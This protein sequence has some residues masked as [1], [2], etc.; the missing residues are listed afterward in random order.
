MLDEPQPIGTSAARDLKLIDAAQ[1]E[2]EEALRRAAQT[3]AVRN[4]PGSG[5]VAAL[6]LPDALPGY[7]IL[8][9]IHRGGQGV[10]YQ[11][12]QKSTQRKV[13]IKVLHEGPF[14]GPRSRVRFER[15][16]Q[17]LGALNHPNIVT[18]HDSGRAAGD[19]LYYVMDYVRGRSLREFVRERKLALEPAL[20]LFATVCEAVQHAHTRGIIHRDLKPGNILVDAEGRAIVVDFGFGKLLTGTGNPSGSPAVSMTQ[21]VMGT[22]AY[23]SPEQTHG[24]ADEIDTRTDVYS[25]GVILYELLT[26][27]HPYTTTG[28][29]PDVVHEIREAEPTPPSRSWSVDS[30]IATRSTRR[31]VAGR[32]PIDDEV[33]TIVL[34]CLAKEPARRYQSAGEIAR[35]L[36]H[37]RAGQPIEAKRDSFGYLLR[38][39]V[40]RHKIPLGIAAFIAIV[41]AGGLVSSISF[42]RQAL[43]DRDRARAINQYLQDM[44]A[45]A[46]PHRVLGQPNATVRQMLDQAT[47]RVEAGGLRDHPEIEAAVRATLGRAYRGLGVLDSAETHLRAGLKIRRGLLGREHAEVA[48]SSR[49]LAWVLDEQGKLDE[50]EPLFRDAL[51]IRRHLFGDQHIDVA[52]SMNDL[53]ILLRDQGRPADA[54][55]LLRDALAI[56]RRLRGDEDPE[57]AMVL[58]GL[59]MALHDQGRMPDAIA[60]SREAIALQ[61]KL[62]GPE[63]LDLAASMSNLALML[64]SNGEAF[65]AESLARGALEM[66]RHLLGEVHPDVAY[67]LNSL[68]TVLRA[69]GRLDDSEALFGEALAMRRKILDESHPDLADSL[70][71]LAM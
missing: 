30:G 57:V 55:R 18:I 5:A 62:L 60:A 21:D 40:R 31:L 56:R 22:L 59:A 70:A 35:D 33:Q 20:E 41:I 65:D 16:V 32:C 71:A 45:S 53:G 51:E 11:A 8:R 46:D 15:E 54:E 44:L 27:R 7:E 49:D 25:L 6:T 14:A 2:A 28:S 69:Q 48:E 10:V 12:I 38:A 52:T 3:A 13:A 43:A 61:R 37:Y 42:W 50:A 68:A 17:I 58:N 24:N 36:R 4:S 39:Q 66:R 63:H 23:M 34:R 67:S 19:A 1:R 26:G 9:E 47:Q 64:T 29:M